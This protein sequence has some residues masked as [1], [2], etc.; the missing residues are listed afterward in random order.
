MNTLIGGHALGH[1]REA[2]LDSLGALEEGKVTQWYEALMDEDMLL[3][4]P[5]NQPKGWAEKNAQERGLWL[6][7]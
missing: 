7:G 2:M 4:Y 5:Q 3:L 1:I 6:I